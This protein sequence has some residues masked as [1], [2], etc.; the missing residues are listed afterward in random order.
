[1]RLE[2]GAKEKRVDPGIFLL[3]TP[4]LHGLAALQVAD[5]ESIDGRSDWCAIGTVSGSTKEKSRS[6]AWKRERSCEV[7]RRRGRS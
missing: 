6:T 3:I 5:D 7:M 1:M 2:D 4:Y